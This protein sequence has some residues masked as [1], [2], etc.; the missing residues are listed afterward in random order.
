MLQKV[1]PTYAT[2]ASYC[3]AMAR[4][5]L[6]YKETASVHVDTQSGLF[7]LFLSQSDS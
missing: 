4:D 5:S 2:I 7:L 3:Y 6:T 1:W